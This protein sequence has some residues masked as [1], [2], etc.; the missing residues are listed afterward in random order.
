MEGA[1]FDYLTRR[2][3]GAAPRRLGRRRLTAGA[4]AALFGIGAPRLGAAACARNGETCDPKKPRR[5]CSG[6][7]V[8]R[9]RK[10]RGHA[11]RPRPAA[12]P[13][14][15]PDPL[16]CTVQ[17]DFCVSSF[18]F[19]P[20]NPDGECVVL[21]DGRPFCALTLGCVDCATDADCDARVGDPHAGGRCVKDCPRCNLQGNNFCVFATVIR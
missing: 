21:D 17:D 10:G 5:C 8:K 14:P 6:T 12:A 15:V 2:F 18:R 11:C 3:A 7:C 1:R 19:C 20:D 13:G 16:G 9:K 4:L